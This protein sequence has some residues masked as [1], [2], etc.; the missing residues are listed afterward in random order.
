MRTDVDGIGWNWTRQGK[1][2]APVV[3]LIHAVGLDLS[4]WKEQIQVLAPN[5]DVIAIDLPG[6]G[7]S[8]AP[9]A[10][11]SFEKAAAGVV[12]ILDD[13]D[14]RAAHLVGLSIGGMIAQEAAISYPTRIRS[15]IL[16]ATAAAFPDETRAAMLQHAA[17]AQGQ[18]MQAVLPFVQY[19][20]ASETAQ[21]QPDILDRI[22]SSLLRLDASDYA[23][24]WRMIAG[25]DVSTR[26]HTVRC[27]T[28]VLVGDRDFNTPEVYAVALAAALRQSHVTVLPGASHL[29]PVDLPSVTTS[30]I[31]NWLAGTGST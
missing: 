24:I 30:A 9:P 7:Q 23:L 27:P 2:G 29:I 21:D 8:A 4:Y 26:L 3:V 16:L 13:A 25:F 5:Y 12:A 19:W 10:D 28:L 11:W 1:R 15:L 22:S 20:V 17:L 14:V 31:E 6:H 18:G